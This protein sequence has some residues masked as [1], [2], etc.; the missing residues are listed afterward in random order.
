MTSSTPAVRPVLRGA[1]VLSLLPALAAPA[2]MAQ[3]CTL[4]AIALAAGERGMAVV[5]ERACAAL[6]AHPEIRPRFAAGGSRRAEAA[7]AP[8]AGGIAMT[9]KSLPKRIVICLD[10]TWN[11][12]AKLAERDD[13]DRVFKPTNV[14]KTSRAVRRLDDR[15]AALVLNDRPS[16]GA[17]VRIDGKTY[18]FVAAP[19]ADGEVLI[20][21]DA[22]TT[23][24]NLRFAIDR[25]R[26]AGGRY[27]PATT[28][29]PTVTAKRVPGDRTCLEL[30][31]RDG[32]RGGDPFAV[33]AR[34]AAGYWADKAGPA[35]LARRRGLDPTPGI[36]QITY[37]DV[38]V[39]ALRRFP[40]ISNRVHRTIDQLFG[41]AAGAGFEANVEDA[42]TFLALNYVEGDEIFV[43]GFS[44]GAATARG[45]CRF[46]DWM[47]GILPPQDA[48]WIPRYFD[49][50]LAGA[51]A[52]DLR[53]GIFDEAVARRLARG[54]DRQRA[55]RE[56]RRITG[57]VVPARVR[58]LGVWDTVLA[59]GERRE[60][61]HVGAAPPAVVDHARQAL[62]IDERRA[63]FRP[64]IWQRRAAGNPRQTL[65]QRWFPGVHSNVGGGYVHD[66]LANLALHWMLRQARD[67]GL[68]L[69][70]RFLSRYPGYAQDRLYNSSKR[71]WRILQTV[72]MQRNKGVRRLWTSDPAG[73]AF[74]P[75]VFLR[76]ATE[77]RAGDRV[78]ERFTP[79]RPPNLLR[80]LA[81]L[82]DL[83]GFLATVPG[84]PEGF[85]LPEE[86]REAVRRAR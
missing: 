17:W 62:A 74:H 16:P 54:R 83:D 3:D 19:A 29:H 53:R 24:D 65:E 4:R 49:G 11:N 10:G 69:D 71:H 68:G 14:L 50:F 82:P 6:G 64:R 47:G 48:Y 18:R 21:D 41:G 5:V 46:I 7:G 28:P 56:A 59:L 45:L 34:L 39:G 25:R 78:H 37:Y 32:A 63:A 40:G 70:W 1:A 20:G 57:T 15:T 26:N 31:A 36:P 84:L 13:G 35:R 22:A 30:V 85:V 9:G 81:T 58:F 67:V 55:E 72:T 2:A 75:S 42:Y 79:Y 51:S 27:G 76:L 33:E 43:F 60:R 12:P 86:V 77:Q 8:A 44:R 61:P 38:G 23:L 52:A 73:L 80:F 66:G